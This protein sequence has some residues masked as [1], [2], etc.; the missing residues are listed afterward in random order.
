MSDNLPGGWGPSL[1]DLDRRRTDARAMGG[2][3]RLGRH[4]ST[5][6]LDAPSRVAEL[7]DPGSFRELGTLVGDVPADAFVAGT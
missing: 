1:D 5:G 6:K 3:E 7:L 4:R 2:E